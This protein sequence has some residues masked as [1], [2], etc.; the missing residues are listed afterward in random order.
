MWEDL[1]NCQGQQKVQIPLFQLSL[2]MVTLWK[3]LVENR[4]GPVKSTCIYRSLKVSQT[5]MVIRSRLGNTR[6]RV[7]RAGVW[8]RR[9][10]DHVEA[11]DTSL[12]GWQKV[13]AWE[14][15][16]SATVSACVLCVY[17]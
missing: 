9:C 12:Q 8:H 17:F 16:G 1:V 4:K 11:R 7:D 15:C 6:D 13:A 3:E 14:S 10:A 5:L 2:I